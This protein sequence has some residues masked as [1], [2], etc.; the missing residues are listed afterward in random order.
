MGFVASSILPVTAS[1]L[2]KISVGAKNTA[3]HL[4]REYWAL[5]GNLPGRLLVDWLFLGKS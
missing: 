5:V 4:V 2:E 1:V 3:V